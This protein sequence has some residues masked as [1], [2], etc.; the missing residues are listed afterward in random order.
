MADPFPAWVDALEARHTKSLTFAEVRRA[1]QALSS[2]YVQRR[3]KL[4][5]GEALGTAG[6]RA[7]FA[8]YYGPL[9]FLAVRGIVRGLGASRPAPQ[10]VLDLGCGTGV[11][12]AAWALEAGARCRVVGV[13]R[14]GW[15]IEEAR[16]TLARLGVRGETRRG[17]VLRAPL[18][19]KRGAIVSAFV[20]NELTDEAREV[21]LER[22]L[23]AGREGARLLVVEPIARGVTP[24]WPRWA[25]AFGG[26]GGRSDEW[27]FPAELPPRL[28]L[29]DRAAG[30]DH[31]DLTAR[32]L[33]LG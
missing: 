5:E 8:L 3:G 11:A 6:K 7:A 19:G 14:S 27:R 32:S 21:L 2:L 30:L 24:W 28:A 33:W 31:R 18:P 12:G 17:D 26:A 23:A 15:A 13:D 1:L 16:F 9:H 29:L 20:A 10:E 4:P 25:E 22:L